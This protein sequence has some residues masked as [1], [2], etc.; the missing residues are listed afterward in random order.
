MVCWESCDVT[1]TRAAPSLQNSFC[2]GI[3]ALQPLIS[4]PWTSS[5]TGTTGRNQG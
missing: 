5:K 2:G 4:C 3:Q 1:V